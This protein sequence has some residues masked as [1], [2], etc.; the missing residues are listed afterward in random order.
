MKLVPF[1]GDEETP[2]LYLCHVR[3]RK[4]TLTRSQSHG[5][6]DFRLPSFSN[7]DEQMHAVYKPHTLWYSCPNSLN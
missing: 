1:Q 2:D 6:A 4:W 7:C 5:H 3:A